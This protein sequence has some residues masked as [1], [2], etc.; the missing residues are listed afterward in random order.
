MGTA[1]VTLRDVADTDLPVFFEQQREPEANRMAD[2]APREREAFLAHWAK[3]RSDPTVTLRTV[4]CD[5]RVA[6]NIVSWERD[7]RRE[8]GYW[9]GRDFWGRGVATRALGAFLEGVVA[10]PVYAYVAAHNVASE[11]VLEK[12]GFFVV[13]E[14][15]GGL[16]LRLDRIASSTG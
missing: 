16:I 5:G 15:P 1:G 13:G 9:L 11:R 3:I 10:R 14:E 2:F 12:C 7:G 4:V 6:G 8:V